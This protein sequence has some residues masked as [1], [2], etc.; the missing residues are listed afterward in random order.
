MEERF[1]VLLFFFVMNSTSQNRSKAT[2]PSCVLLK[3]PPIGFLTKQGTVIQ[4]QFLHCTVYDGQSTPMKGPR[5]LKVSFDISWPLNAVGVDKSHNNTPFDIILTIFCA[6]S[7]QL[8]LSNEQN[9]VN[10]NIFL[11]MFTSSYCRVWSQ[12]L[13]T[14]AKI[15]D[16]VGMGSEGS[17]TNSIQGNKCLASN[18]QNIV[19]LDYFYS[20]ITNIP[21]MFTDPKNV[22]P[23]MASNGCS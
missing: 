14:W 20:S 1:F 19:Y 4:Q 7:V 13:V 21:N 3:A 11:G 17:V 16:L 23:D 6:S 12:N 18:F 5:I 15:T 2:P 22:W 9:L 10:K 8:D